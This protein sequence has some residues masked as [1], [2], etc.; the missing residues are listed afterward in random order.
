MLLAR[1]PAP[2]KP[3]ANENVTQQR[4]PADA[5]ALRARVPSPATLVRRS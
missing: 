4:A 3:A 1:L 5:L 2:L